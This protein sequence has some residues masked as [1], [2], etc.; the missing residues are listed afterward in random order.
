MSYLTSSIESVFKY[1]LRSSMITGFYLAA[2]N[3]TG[4]G[5]LGTTTSGN[6]SI[7]QFT[8]SATGVYTINL[9]NLFGRN[10]TY[11]KNSS[12]KAIIPTIKNAVSSS[13]TANGSYYGLNVNYTSTSTSGNINIMAYNASGTLTNLDL[14]TKSL[15]VSIYSSSAYSNPNP[16][17][18]SK[19]N[20]VPTQPTCNYDNTTI[21][22]FFIDLSTPSSPVSSDQF[23]SVA[24]VSANKYTISCRYS[25]IPIGFESSLVLSSTSAAVPCR[26]YA[27]LPVLS[28]TAT[29]F[30]IRIDS[31]TSS[32]ITTGWSGLFFVLTLSADTSVINNCGPAYTLP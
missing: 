22:P 20:L 18:S 28:T 21:I 4:Q 6:G 25:G 16:L 3:S 5:T 15:Y 29:T 30:D 8:N 9:I 11:F 23:I 7:M 14:T 17:G 32:T 26:V 24:Y 2:G 12:I 1:P 13:V 10:N 27:S 31:M 19:V